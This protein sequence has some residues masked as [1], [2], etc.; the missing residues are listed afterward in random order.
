MFVYH[1]YPVMFL[2]VCRPLY[3]KG[4]KSVPP[5]LSCFREIHSDTV[6][7]LCVFYGPIGTG[8]HLMGRMGL[9]VRVNA[10]FQKIAPSRGS[11]RVMTPS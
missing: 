9:G 7:H 11:I 4:Y 8:P 10:S 2:P 5:A 3:Q 1:Q 6:V